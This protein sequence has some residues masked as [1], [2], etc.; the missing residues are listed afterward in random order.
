MACCILIAAAIALSL[1][2]KRRI[3]GRRR[4]ETDPRAWRLPL[5]E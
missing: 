1:A 3:F 2:L 5:E 4:G